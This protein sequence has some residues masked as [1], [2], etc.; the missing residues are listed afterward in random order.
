MLLIYTTYNRISRA[1]RMSMEPFWKSLARGKVSGS[2]SSSGFSQV[3]LN[4]TVLRAVHA[5]TTESP[6][7]TETFRGGTMVGGGSVGTH[8]RFTWHAL[9]KHIYIT[10]VTAR[11]GTAR[12]GTARH[13]T[14][15]HGTARHGTARHGTAR[16]GNTALHSMARHS[17][18]YII[19]QRR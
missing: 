14:A 19:M 13:G 2:K 17:T 11:H 3:M 16:H 6:G 10:I 15:R 7:S 8:Q 12:H 5:S 4:G 18:A 1:Y 9:A